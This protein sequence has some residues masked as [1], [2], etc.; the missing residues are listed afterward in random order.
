MEDNMKPLKQLV[1][2]GKVK[3]RSCIFCYLSY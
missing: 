3:K 1:E 2:E